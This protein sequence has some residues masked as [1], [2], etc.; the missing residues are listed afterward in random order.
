LASALEVAEDALSLLL[1]D[2]GAHLGGGLHLVANGDVFQSVDARIDEPVVDRPVDQ[3]SRRV[4]ADLSGM[5]RDR[6]DQLLDGLRDVH[7]IKNDGRTLAA[8]FKLDGDEVAP[9]GR[10]D[11]SSDFGRAVNDIRLS[12]DEPPR[13]PLS[14]HPTPAPR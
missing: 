1:A 2:D 5:E 12:P 11:E 6:L 13:P 8:Q 3:P 10:S 14:G 9:A 7:I 4:T